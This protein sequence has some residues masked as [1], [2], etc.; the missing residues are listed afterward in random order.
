[1]RSRRE[2]VRVTVS[3]FGTALLDGCVR[4]PAMSGAH[5]PQ[6]TA[7]DFVFQGDPGR[8]F[9]A[10]SYGAVGDGTHDDS[11]AIEAA[12]RAASSARGVVEFTPGTYRVTRRI[13]ARSNMGVRGRGAAADVILKGDGTNK[14]IQFDRCENFFVQGLTFD[15]N[16][17][18]DFP[19]A[20]DCENAARFAIRLCRF[21][22][23]R[24]AETPPGQTMQGI[25]CRGCRS[26]WITDNVSLGQQFKLAGVAGGQDAFIARNTFTDPS[27]HAISFVSLGHESVMARVTIV[28]NVIRVAATAGI[29]VGSDFRSPDRVIHTRDILIANNRL[30]GAPRRAGEYIS[31]FFGLGTNENVVIRNNHITNDTGQPGNGISAIVVQDRAERGVQALRNLQIIDNVV[32]GPID[33]WG[34]RVDPPNGGTVSELLVARNTLRQCRGMTVRNASGR[35]AGNECYELTGAGRLVVRNSDVDIEDNLVDTANPA[36]DAAPRPAAPAGRRQRGSGAAGAI[37]LEAEAGETLRARVRRNRVR[38][39]RG[40]GGLAFGIVEAGEGRFA[41]EYDANDITGAATPLRRRSP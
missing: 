11:E 4:P 39:S 12:F 6:D 26:F 16:G 13:A 9:A 19:W 33:Q 5:R 27:Q 30:T 25:L 36:D 34:I 18:R 28:D 32:E 10:A 40:G 35:I 41:V 38:N 37:R 7:A 29:Y 20:V 21:V 1:M 17:V 8:I 15:T 2:F 3:A 24:A 23:S 22:N 14:L 31:V